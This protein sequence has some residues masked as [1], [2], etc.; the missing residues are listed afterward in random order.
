MGGGG[1][2]EESG[3]EGREESVS[4]MYFIF[5]SSYSSDLKIKTVMKQKC[6]V[7]FTVSI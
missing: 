7:S 3:G 6:I 2:K 4:N 5:A 1:G